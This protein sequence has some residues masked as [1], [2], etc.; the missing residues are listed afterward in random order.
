MKI[1]P[2]R[3]ELFHADRGTDKW[4][5]DQADRHDEADGSFLKYCET[6]KIHSKQRSLCSSQMFYLHEYSFKPCR[7][8]VQ[9]VP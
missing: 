9:T 1:L 7:D 6:P 8:V 3:T 2:V 5:E 4:T